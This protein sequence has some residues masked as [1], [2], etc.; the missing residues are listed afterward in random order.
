MPFISEGIE[1]VKIIEFLQQTEGII[2][3]NEPFLEVETE[4]YLLELPSRFEGK[5][6]KYFIKKGE[7]VKEGDDICLVYKD[8]YLEKIKT[9][10]TCIS[11]LEIHLKKIEENSLFFLELK[12]ILG[13]PYESKQNEII[14]K[15]K[16]LL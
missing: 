8:N 11:E 9:I 10:S 14:K 5:I 3:L 4:N 16:T 13:L 6:V 12:D 1:E 7:Y 15:I 2:N